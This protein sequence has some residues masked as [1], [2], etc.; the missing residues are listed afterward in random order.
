MV[1]YR[2]YRPQ[3]FD[4]L[5]GQDHVKKTLLAAFASGKLAHAYLFCGPRGSGKTSTARILAKLVNCESQQSVVSNQSSAKKAESRELKADSELPCNKCSA[6]ISITDGSNLDLIEI[7][8]ASNR[9]IDDIR[10]LREKIKLAPSSLKKKVYIIDEVHMLTAEAFNALLKTLE[11]PPA[12]VLFILATTEVHKL[13]VT[14]LSRVSRFD[15]KQASPQDL[16]LALTN[17]TRKEKL[18]LTDEILDLIAQVSEGSFRDAVKNLDQISSYG[19]EISME[20]ARSVLKAND[21]SEITYLLE[22]IIDKDSKEALSLIQAINEK[23]INIKEFINSVLRTLRNILLIKNGAEEGVKLEIGTGRWEILKMLSEKIN[24]DKLILYLE[25]FHKSLEQLKYTTIPSLPLEVA[26][27]KSINQLSVPG[28]QLS[29][30]SQP[31]LVKPVSETE[32]QKT[33]RPM[34]DTRQLKTENR[35]IPSVETMQTSDDAIVITDKWTYILE[36][37]RP[38]NYSL[39]ALL[40]QA[41]V[42]NCDGANVI[43]EVPYSFH[44]RILEAPKSKSLLES[45]LADVLGK[46]VKITTVLGKRVLRQEELANVEVAQDDEIVRLASEIFN[47]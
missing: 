32:K 39:E 36:T 3:N 31:V 4:E 45:V 8:A 7:D 37:I 9:G 25:N 44:Q 23:G 33:D 5:I 42:L 22:K 40:K 41:K 19:K 12:H 35:D 46:S 2:K 29:D 27:V 6:C 43:L 34:P 10:S 11:E 18:K 24:Q 15:F 30:K 16:K 1:F 13:P 26:V 38:Y 28:S 17:I 20:E 14:I 47:S 21:F